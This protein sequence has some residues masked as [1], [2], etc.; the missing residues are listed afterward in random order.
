MRSRRRKQ[1]DE[2]EPIELAALADG[3]LAGERRDALKAE[4]QGSE[5][6][7]ALLAEQERAVFL[8]HGAAADVEAPAGLRRRV[9]AERHRRRTRTVRPLTL[10]GAAATVAAAALVLLLLLPAGAGG[11]T[12]AEAA[13]LAQRPATGPAPPARADEPKLLSRD[14]EGVA[15]PSWTEKFGWRATGERADTLEGRRTATVFYRK[16]SREIA[17]TIVGGNALDVPD[18]AQTVRRE[19]TNL[20]VFRQGGR[21][22]VTWLRLG[23]TCV[24]SAAGVDQDVLVKLAA[25]KGKGA[26]DF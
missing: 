18:D 19:G 2:R 15:F 22:V 6:L 11:P 5:E 16:E 25:W 4:V 8:L 14:V 13:T 10:A 26:V 21:L 12:V 7:A 23:R 20:R 24:L 9:D 3:S 17:Y 1:P